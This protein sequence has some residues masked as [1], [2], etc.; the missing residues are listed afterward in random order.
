VSERTRKK[1][2]KVSSFTKTTPALTPSL[3]KPLA[4][5]APVLRAGSAASLSQLQ[6]GGRLPTSKAEILKLE[7]KVAADPDKLTPWSKEQLKADPKEFLRDVVQL[8]GL[9]ETASDRSACGP[10]ALLMGMIA[11]RPEALIE[12]GG[13]L[14][15]PNG[16][17]AP[18]GQALVD[19]LRAG[20]G[21]PTDKAA[22]ES[23]VG[24]LAP[25]LQRLQAGREFL[26]GDVT[27]LAEAMQKYAQQGA[28]T[29]MNGADLRSI[30]RAIE[31]MGVRLPPM[32]LELYGSGKGT[33]HWRVVSG[34]TQFNPWPDK[35]G[36]ASQ[37]PVADGQRDGA[38][39]GA[40]W[41]RREQVTLD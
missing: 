10:A 14:M 22:V 26:P 28:Q 36:K 2:G 3:Q 20:A 34:D 4:T 37:L 5:D 35:N 24:L 17:L 29:G 6:S 21:S 39:D 18:A 19:S 33:G 15:K 27:I 8:D 41:T 25:A 40:G 9:T 32:T 12:L 16:E 23:L 30:A 13:K 31:G 38:K 11:G 1:T 7:A